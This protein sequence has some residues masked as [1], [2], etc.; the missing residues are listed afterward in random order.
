MVVNMIDF[1]YMGDIAFLKA[2]FSDRQIILQLKTKH[3][4]KPFYY[5]NY[6]VFMIICTVGCIKKSQ[7]TFSKLVI[8][9]T[10]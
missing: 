5:F 3:V 6:I 10:T 9:L 7:S 1:Y 8:S 2:I 4:H